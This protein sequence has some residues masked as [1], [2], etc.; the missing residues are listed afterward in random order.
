MDQARNTDVDKIE[1]IASQLGHLT[2]QPELSFVERI[3]NKNFENEKHKEKFF[4]NITRLLISFLEELQKHEKLLNQLKAFFSKDGLEINAELFENSRKLNNFFNG[5]I[6][7]LIFFNRLESLNNKVN[8][9]IKSLRIEFQETVSQN[10]ST[11]SGFIIEIK[12]IVK[13]IKAHFLYFE[14]CQALGFNKIIEFETLKNL[15]ISELFQLDLKAQEKPRCQI[16]LHCLD[17][18]SHT[19]L[20]SGDFHIACINYWINVIDNNS[21]F[22]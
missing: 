6:R 5:I 9:N 21:P 17:L 10:I 1:D 19:K 8:E 13:K 22:N 14:T 18:D 12:K 2:Y 15:E 20:F 3:F 11:N 16:C 7:L 4:E